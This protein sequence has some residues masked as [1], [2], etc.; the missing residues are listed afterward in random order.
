MVVLLTVEA[1]EGTIN[2]LVAHVAPQS[3]VARCY[4]TPQSRVPDVY[5]FETNIAFFKENLSEKIT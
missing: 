1:K 4:Q 5:K 3:R 2:G